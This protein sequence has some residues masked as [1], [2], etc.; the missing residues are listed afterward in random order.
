LFI[1]AKGE[2]TDGNETNNVYRAIQH[3][4][5]DYD[6]IPSANID[7]GNLSSVRSSWGVGR[8]IKER[9]SSLDY[10]IEL[11]KHSFVAYWQKRGGQLAL[12][13]WREDTTNQAD[14]DDDIILRG[15]LKG[16][17]RSDLANAY[18]EFSIKYGWSNA[19]EKY[20]SEFFVTRTDEDTFPASDDDDWKT[21]VGGVSAGS[22]ADAKAR[23]D[24]CHAA[25]LE[26]MAINRLEMECPWFPDMSL[27]DGYTGG[28]I[29]V[30]SSAFKL[31][32]NLVSWSTRQKNIV[33]YSVPITAETVALELMQY[34]T[35]VDSF[36][37]DSVTH[38]GRIIGLQNDPKNIS[39]DISLMLDSVTAAEDDF[40]LIIETGSAAKQYSEAGDNTLQIVEGGV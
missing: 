20:E 35:F 21:Y 34:V 23:W 38:S 18:N 17:S 12:S 32:Q 29:G 36:V 10:I 2:T 1:G 22:Y 4:M 14:H 31:L 39:R 25:Y 16:M 26:T 24:V 3:I 27:F 30:G 9:M 11:C 15:T 28:Q 40:N 33:T 7:F 13:A 37:T 8:Q 19:T 6:G 5:L